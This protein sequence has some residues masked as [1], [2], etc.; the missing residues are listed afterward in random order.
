MDFCLVKFNYVNHRGEAAERTVRPIRIW[1]GSTA[2]HTET[3]WFLEGFCLDRKESRDFAM[4]N[5]SQWRRT[6]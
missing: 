1:F 6:C 4:S 3:Q 2:W 5:I